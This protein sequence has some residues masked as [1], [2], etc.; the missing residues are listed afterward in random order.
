[1]YPCYGDYWLVGVP[2]ELG[3][4]YAHQYD[5][6]DDYDVYLFWPSASQALVPADGWYPEEVSRSLVSDIFS[7]L[8]LLV[9]M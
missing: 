8:V 9:L 6:D 2:S 4:N 3:Y 1:M 5:V 7:F